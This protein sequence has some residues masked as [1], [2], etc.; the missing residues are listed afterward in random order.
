MW[1]EEIVAEAASRHTI[2]LLEAAWTSALH[3]NLRSFAPNFG[4]YLLGLEELD[5]PR[6]PLDIPF[7][8]W[9][10]EQ[11]PGLEGNV[12]TD[13]RH[14]YAEVVKHL[15]PSFP[16]PAIYRAIQYLHEADRDA[17]TLTDYLASWRAAA[18][19]DDRSAVE[20]IAAVIAS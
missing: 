17:I 8:A 11:M 1:I 20:A 3:E 10:E 19:S 9:I 5:E 7:H 13:R 15:R 18:P 12:A 2:P 16:A 4:S 6:R 14:E